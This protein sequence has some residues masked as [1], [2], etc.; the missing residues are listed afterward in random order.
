MNNFTVYPIGNVINEN[1]VCKIQLHPEYVPALLGLDGFS[2]LQI[3]WYFDKLDIPEAREVLQTPK[4]Y[5]LAPDTL[6][7][8]ATRGPVRPNPL[9]LTCVKVFQIDHKTGTLQIEFIDA[10]NNS[11]VLDIKP[12]TPSF[13]KIT[14][15]QVP[16]W[17]NHW[18]KTREESAEF[19]WD[20]EMN[21]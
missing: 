10:E 21:F 8:F 2:H 19:N 13:D 16:T 1:G 18:P 7:I 17:C 3:L 4:P 20:A 15:P 14:T 5:K 6:G 9:A 11:P 12:Y